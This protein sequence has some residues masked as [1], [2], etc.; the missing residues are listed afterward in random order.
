MENGAHSG[1]YQQFNALPAATDGDG[2]A[3]LQSA[4]RAS[5]YN[6]IMTRL[7]R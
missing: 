6:P 2:I 4:L 1:L 7:K 5:S 3:H